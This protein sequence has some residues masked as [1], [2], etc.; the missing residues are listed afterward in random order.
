MMFIDLQH[1]F[2][3]NIDGVGEGVKINSERDEIGT[4]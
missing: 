1:I 3:S 2:V 4:G